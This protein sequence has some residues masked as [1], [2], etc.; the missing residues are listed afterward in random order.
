MKRVTVGVLAHVDA[1]KTTLTEAMMYVS[2]NIKKLGRVDHKDT[3]LDN[4]SLERDRGITIFSK[5]ALL[6]Y[7][8]T[9]FFLLDTP[10]HI[11]F[12]CEA[13]RS[14]QVCDYAVLVISGTDGVQSHT[15]TLWKLLRKYSVPTFLFINKMDLDGA[16]KALLLSDLKNKLSDGCV[17][18]CENDRKILFENIALCNEELLSRY[19]ETETIKDEDIVAAV[20]ER[21]L[22]PCF[23]GSALKVDGI[24]RFLNALCRCTVMPDYPDTFSARVF[25]ISEDKAKN[26]LSFLKITGGALRVRDILHSDKNKNQEKVTQIRLYSGEKFTA[27]DE[28][29]AGTICAVTG[30][31][32]TQAG[33][34]LGEEKGAFL[35]FLEPVL[36]YKITLPESVD[37]HTALSK[38][39]ILEAE[40]PSLHI[41][42]NERNREISVQLMGEIQLEVLRSAVNE[43][44]SFDI[45]FERGSI[46]YK[47]TITDTVEGVGHFEPLR[48]YAEVHLLLEPLKR[49]EGLLFESNC[50]EDLLD[51]NW[52]RLILGHLY[53]KTHL[54]VLTGSPITD[55][56]ITLMSGKAHLKHTEGGDFREATYRAVRQGLMSARSV[57]LEPY[58]RFTLEVPTEN[59]GRAMND[60]HMMH[61]S[62]S[63]AETMGDTAVLTGEAPAVSMLDY[64][65]TVISYTRGKGKLSCSLK[66]YDVCHNAD[67]VIASI[68]YSAEGDTENPADSVFCSHGAGHTVKWNEVKEHMHLSSCLKD[69]SQ[70]ESVSKQKRDFE[71]YRSANDL[72]ALDKELMEIFEKTYGPVKSRA[73]DYSSKPKRTTLRYDGSKQMKPSPLLTKQKE[74]LLVDGY[75]VIFSWENLK[76]LAKDN[77]DSARNTL[78]NI[79]C[80][81]RGFKKC[82]LILVFDAYKVE[83]SHREV[84]RVNNIDIVYTKEAET[85]DTYIEK[86]SHELIKNNK[87]RVVTSDRMEQLIIVGNGAL[88]VSSKDF[89]E[90]VRNAENEIREIISGD[91]H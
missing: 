86:V 88:Y 80:N 6:K 32:F 70:S 14:L 89:S 3:L 61:G 76:A 53:E 72:F 13:E 37:P 42:W 41:V 71:R 38:L 4:F 85:A 24:D 67:E 34:G 35:P 54:G 69:R 26:R 90:E 39:R 20:R 87:V 48:H 12:S 56:K 74:Y 33:D 64:H 18:F 15:E 25:K 30:V 78:I 11:D 52:Q 23:F 66:G 75:N 16:D 51:K 36:T 73:R 60:I 40:D 57:L 44:F 91:F 55:M 27:L 84:E 77:I 59:L 79:L 31:T 49:D 82:E 21:R 58:Y 62:F 9:D 28:A 45:G 46:L 10:G 19:S 2:G 7:K 1:G 8:D 47:E 68:G 83:G 22:F 29:A 65:K 81:Y 43:R 50:R 17:D 63:P 5:T